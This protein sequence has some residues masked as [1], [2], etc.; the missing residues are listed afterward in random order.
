MGETSFT[1][2]VVMERRIL[3]NR[4]QSEQWVP[5]GVVLD[6]GEPAPPELLYRDGACERWLHAGF[7]VRLYPDEAEGYF[8][9]CT[10]P[11]PVLF[12][13]WRL[14]DAV[15][16]PWLVTASYNE[17]SRALDSGE[18]VEGVPMPAEVL[19]A[20][21]DFVGR[22]YKPEPKKRSKPPSFQG[23]RRDS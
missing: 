12:I 10:T 23:A 5:V 6:A 22:H 21:S 7:E 16:R 15:M 8:L 1:V 19:Q 14:E 18:Q 13:G 4:W 2:G 11:Q 3:N 9:N 17:A 20:V